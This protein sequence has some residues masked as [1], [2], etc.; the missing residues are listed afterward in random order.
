MTALRRGKARRLLHSLKAT[1]LI[2][3]IVRVSTAQGDTM[4]RAAVIDNDLI[5]MHGQRICL[6]GIEAPQSFQ[7]CC[8]EERLGAASSKGPRC[9]IRL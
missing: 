3:D 6:Y 4:G 1:L 7:L 9:W 5:E 8:T 2:L